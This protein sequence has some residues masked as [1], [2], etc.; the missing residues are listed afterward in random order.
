MPTTGGR[1]PHHRRLVLYSGGQERRNALI[2]ADLLKLALARPRRGEPSARQASQG[3][4]R[5]TY[6]P[7]TTEGA[8]PFYARFRRRYAAFG[9]THFD[10]VP[11]DA[12]DP[13]DAARRLAR[14][15]VVYLSGGNTFT[16]LAHLRR[17]GL[18]GILRRFAERGGVLAGL[19]AGAILMTPDIG[20]AAWPP[21]DRD[22]NEVDLPK[23]EW[24]AL[25]LVP[26]DF[27]PHY[28]HSERYRRA[29]ARHVRRTGRPLYACRDGSGLVV[30]GDRLTIHG[31]VWLFDGARPTK[32]GL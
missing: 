21:F 6:V 11:A 24:G 26:F 2:H 17:N 1:R 7:Y 13:R 10:C 22:A 3:G 12:P 19:S 27:F 20:L 4:V 23:S 16:F 30:E 18:L 32:L 9:A 5:M 25:D 15:D 14:S 29:L 8:A 28:R 31:D